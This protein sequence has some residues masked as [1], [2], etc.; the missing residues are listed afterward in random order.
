MLKVCVILFRNQELGLFR[1]WMLFTKILVFL[2][3]LRISIW[4]SPRFPY[5]NLADFHMGIWRIPISIWESG[6]SDFHMGIWR[7]K[8]PYG[9]LADQIP[10]WESG[11]SNSHMEICRISIWSSPVIN[12]GFEKKQGPEIHLFGIRTSFLE[13]QRVNIATKQPNSISPTTQLFPGKVKR[14][15]KTCHA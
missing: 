6:G 4:K 9:N 8:F 10:I 2:K 14:G 13:C 5:G 11:G 15:V 12:V 1:I 7:I 3:I